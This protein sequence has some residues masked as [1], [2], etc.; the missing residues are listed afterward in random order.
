MVPDLISYTDGLAEAGADALREDLLKAPLVDSVFVKWYS[1]KGALAGLKDWEPV[2]GN[3]DGIWQKSI[4]PRL[5]K[6]RDP[7]AV[8]Y[9]D[10]KIKVEGNEA[11]ASRLMMTNKQFADVRKP[12]LLFSRAQEMV[13]VALPNRAAQEMLG[14]VRSYPDHPDN[15]RWVA[16]LE[17]LVGDMNV[18]AEKSAVA[19]NQ[20]GGQGANGQVASVADANQSGH[21]V[22]PGN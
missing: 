18:A 3:S 21:G 13:T 11:A 10:Y 2:P 15:D 14:L 9:W 17:K 4:L 5:R 22:K 6:D 8:A 16:R 7:R 19:A 20:V 1:L 12:A